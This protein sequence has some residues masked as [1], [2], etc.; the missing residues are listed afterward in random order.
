MV[1]ICDSYL[2]INNKIT[3]FMDHSV[4]QPFHNTTRSYLH[5]HMLFVY[6]CNW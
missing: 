1:N 6:K 4:N 2:K 3:R 5:C